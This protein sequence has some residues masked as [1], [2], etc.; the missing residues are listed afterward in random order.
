[1]VRREKK[2]KRRRKEEKK[3]EKLKRIIEK[4]NNTYLFVLLSRLLL[5]LVLSVQCLDH[6]PLSLC[7]LSWH[8]PNITL[9]RRAEEGK[10][11]RERVEE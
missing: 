6:T 10:R 1:M 8:A 11:K 2:Y 7:L 3:E 4:K 5:S 9:K